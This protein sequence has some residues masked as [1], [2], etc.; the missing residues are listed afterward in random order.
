M[1][2]KG[3]ETPPNIQYE[4]CLVDGY[5]FNGLDVDKLTTKIDSIIL[6]E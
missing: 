2:N 3:F 1:N 6:K 4:N 5:S